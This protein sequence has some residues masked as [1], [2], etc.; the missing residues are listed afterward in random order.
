MLKD[1]FFYPLALA[2]IAGMVWF[3]LSRASAS[4]LTDACI[5][6]NGYVSQGEDL[7]RLT[8]SPGTSYEY[9]G[10]TSKDPAHI[11][12][13][14]QI[15]RKNIDPS[16]GV[17]APL[18]PDYERAFAGQKIRLTVRARQGRKDPLEEFDMA[19]FTS[20]VGNTGWQRYKLTPKW[21]NYSLDYTPGLPNGDPDLDY[22][23]VWPGED[24]EQKTMDIEF[25][26]VDVLSKPVNLAKECPASTS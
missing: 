6:Q 18:G 1:R 26:K 7:A 21:K 25:M 3:A 15:A 17:F 11:V 16:A 23:G 2:L 12:A 8:A 19:Y 9:M 20:G 22:F 14:T 13:M 24:G 4:K 10:A 5:W